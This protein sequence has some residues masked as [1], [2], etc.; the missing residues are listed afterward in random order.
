MTLTIGRATG[1]RLSRAV[2]FAGDT[3]E[4]G[5]TIVAASNAELQARRQQLLGLVENQD[6]TVFPITYQ[7]DASL[8]GYYLV[9]AVAAEPVGAIN[10][11]TGRFSLTLER[12]PGY[13]SPVI[14]LIYSQSEI[15][16]AAIATQPWLIWPKT[17]QFADT[18]ITPTS[19]RVTETGEVWMIG[20]SSSAPISFRYSA[21]PMNYYD[22]SVRLEGLY[23]GTYYSLIGAQGPSSVSVL[24]ISNGLVRLS[25]TSGGE[26]VLEVFSGGAWRATSTNFRLVYGGNTATV[27]S[28]VKIVRNS[29]EQVTV[30]VQMGRALTLGNET[31]I[32]TDITLRRGAAHFDIVGNLGQRLLSLQ[33]VT[34]TASTQ[35]T[36]NTFLRQ[37]S[38]DANGNRWFL[39]SKQTGA[40]DLVNGRWTQTAGP[41][42]NDYI[43][44]GLGVQVGGSGAVGVDADTSLIAAACSFSA[45]QQRVQVR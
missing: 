17:W 35:I 44:L 15:P 8:D 30:R 10:T 41:S 34:N 25:I 39:G 23:G 43:P 18:S 11:A 21:P 27:P 33:A 2:R 36:A 42:T 45:H 31:A 28:P 19:G 38:N 26:L 3:L 12:V 4:L 6:E 9:R 1:L 7:G 20:A 5:G 13:Q 16:G 37:T 32:I 40:L 22:A 24:R 29:P 14:E